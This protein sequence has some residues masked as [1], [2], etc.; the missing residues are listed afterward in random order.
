MF[1]SH[2]SNQM[3]IITRITSFLNL[4]FAVVLLFFF[5]CIQSKFHHFDL[6]ITIFFFS[7]F[8]LCVLI[9]AQ[10]LIKLSDFEKYEIDKHFLLS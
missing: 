4:N 3:S 10:F 1:H 2:S 5:T 6:W 9:L 7:S 8:R